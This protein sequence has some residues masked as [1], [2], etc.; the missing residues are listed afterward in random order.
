MQDGVTRQDAAMTH[1]EAMTGDEAMVR[2]EAAV[3][4]HLV[5]V[6][7]MGSGKTTIGARLAERLGWPFRDSDAELQ[8]QTGRT[9]RVL[10]DEA[11][12][13]AMHAL[14]AQ[15]LLDAL[16]ISTVSVVAAAAS[17]IEVAECRA[18]L[19]R[20]GIVV[21]WL[22]GSADV[23]ASRFAR[24]AHRPAYGDDPATFLADQA[25]RR[26]PLFAGLHPVVVDV[27]RDDPAT[28]VERIV[29]AIASTAGPTTAGPTAAPTTPGA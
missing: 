11:G 24:E 8:A 17:V 25:T 10:R 4:R 13:E 22:R 19:S 12:V 14:E 28:L 7:L 3:I 26:E 9:V 2:D 29:R 27:D 23:L 6:G 20:P 5:L 1:D 21:V 18:A 16:A 15:Q